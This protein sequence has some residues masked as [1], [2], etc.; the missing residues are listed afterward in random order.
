MSFGWNHYV[1]VLRLKPGEL[2]ALRYLASDVRESVTPIVEVLPKNLGR[3]RSNPEGDLD[4]AV[5]VICEE[6]WKVWGDRNFF[7]DTDNVSD[8]AIEAHVLATFAADALAEK[9]LVTPMIALRNSST[10]LS[11]VQR[12][13]GVLNTGC[14]LRLN[15]GDLGK[16]ETAG[17][18]SELTRKLELTPADID[19]IVDLGIST[20]FPPFN[21]V[22]ENL[23]QLL[24]W[25]SF[26]VLSGAFPKDLQDRAPGVHRIPRLDWQHWVSELAVGINGARSPSF[27]DYTVQYGNYVEPPDRPNPSAS[28]RYTSDT[29]WILMRGQGI[30]NK[31]GAGNKQWPANALLL[32]EMPEFCG[33]AFSEGDRYIANH[34]GTYQQA[35][36]PGTWI[37]AAINHHLVF[38]ARQIRGV[39][40]L[41]PAAKELLSLA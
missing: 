10:K 15:R 11:A 23:P 29:E 31:D 8:A 38:T 14:G 16:P 40:G 26:T 27:G 4:V 39:Q 9:L 21:Y 25:R 20:G 3:N 24:E 35:G 32:S 33:P 7:L 13:I 2:W 12:S 22:R 5:K 41:V 34:A 1:P 30:Y 28:I 6:I 19:L 37:R 36:S 17:V 18:I